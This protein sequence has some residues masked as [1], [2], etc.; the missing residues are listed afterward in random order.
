MGSSMVAGRVDDEVKQSAEFYIRR[1]GTTPSEV[2]RVVW[3]NIAKTGE[4]PR[5]V[6][7]APGQNGLVARMRALR[8]QTPRSDFLE[9]LTPE[10]L[11]RELEGRG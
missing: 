9:S 8:E 11:K 4:V 2:I 6:Q 7:D 1:A 5:P 3:A 10:G